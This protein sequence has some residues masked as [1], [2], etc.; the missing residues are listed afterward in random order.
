MQSKALLH[1]RE[2][3][4]NPALLLGEL[5]IKSSVTAYRTVVETQ[6]RTYTK[7]LSKF[8]C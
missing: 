8:I 4:D 5:S 6:Y 7:N 3:G 1:H 2:A